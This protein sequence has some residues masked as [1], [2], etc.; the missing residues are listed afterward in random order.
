MEPERA[1]SLFSSANHAYLATVGAE[2]APHV[3]P[4][5]FFSTDETIYWTVDRKPK[6]GA[7]LQ[8]LINIGH[9]PRVSALADAYSPDWSALWWVRADGIAAEVTGAEATAAIDLLSQKYPQY[10]DARPEG[11][12]VAIAVERWVGWSAG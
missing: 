9:E 7:P 4:F 8:R 3:V 2:G 10:R 1:R 6:S 5:T 11:P 12:V